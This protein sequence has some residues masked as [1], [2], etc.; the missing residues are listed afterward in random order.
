MYT[1]FFG[2]IELR[3]SFYVSARKGGYLF[4]S[5]TNLRSWSRCRSTLHI[6]LAL[7]RRVCL[8]TVRLL[9]HW[10]LCR[11]A[12]DTEAL[13]KTS[14]NRNESL[15]HKTHRSLFIIFIAVASVDSFIILWATP[16]AQLQ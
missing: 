15:P 13:G 10:P 14:L 5:Y 9:Q 12:T 3:K 2:K 8:R 7:W 1:N 4:V 11:R 6:Y 16:A